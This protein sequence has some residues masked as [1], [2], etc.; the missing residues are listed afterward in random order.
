MRTAM[1]SRNNNGRGNKNTIG[2]GGG[3]ILV[4]YM[5]G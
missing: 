2:G 4:N 1:A 3:N 5:A